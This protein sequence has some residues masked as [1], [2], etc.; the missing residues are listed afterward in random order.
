MPS[1]RAEL[2]DLFKVAIG[3]AYP[4]VAEANPPI[5]A[6]CAQTKFGDYQCNNAMSLFA[7]LKGNPACPKAPR[8]VALAV[9]AGLPAGN[10]IVAETSLAGPGF[11]NIRVSR[12]YLAK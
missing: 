5:I 9:V 7:R 11:V 6:A 12:D 2:Y 8:D 10:D 1:V 4:D 3:A